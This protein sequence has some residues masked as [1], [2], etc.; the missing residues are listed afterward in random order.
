MT[1][2]AENL[3]GR[4]AIL[5]A[6]LQAFFEQGF[7]GT[8]MRNIAARAGSATSHCYYYFPSK[9]EV[10]RT[11]IIDVTADLIKSLEAERRAASQNPAAQL[12][13]IVRAHVTLHSER[14]AEAFVGSS[15]LRSLDDAAHRE[16]IDMRDQIGAIFRSVVNDGIQARAFHCPHPNETVLAIMTMCTSVADWYRA[17]GPLTPAELADRY[18]TLALNMVGNVEDTQ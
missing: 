9:S 1:H 3:A 16:A 2:T 14:Q 5:V 11:L 10:L 12:T 4:E 18:A 13:A 15:E 17:D 6:A 7:H 8:S